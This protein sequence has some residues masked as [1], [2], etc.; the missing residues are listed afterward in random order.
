MEGTVLSKRSAREP[1]ASVLCPVFSRRR[2][3]QHL[4]PHAESLGPGEVGGG[5]SSRFQI[6]AQSAATHHTRAAT[7]RVGGLCGLPDESGCGARPPPGAGAFS[8][9]TVFEKGRATVG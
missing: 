6:R 8:I 1:N 2:G 9:A 5:S 3:E 7:E 4:P